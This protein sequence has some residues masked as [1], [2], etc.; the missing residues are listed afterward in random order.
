MSKLQYPTVDMV[1][2]SGL[3]QHP[4][5]NFAPTN[6]IWFQRDEKTDTQGYVTRIGDGAG[7]EKF[8][9]EIFSPQ[10]TELSDGVV[11]SLPLARQAVFDYFK[12]L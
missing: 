4:K 8:K 11:E 12:S 2:S 1:M 10:G 5:R 9:Y 3:Y 7:G 6:A